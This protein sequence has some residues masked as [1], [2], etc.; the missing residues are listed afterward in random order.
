[1]GFVVDRFDS[2]SRSVY[3]KDDYTGHNSKILQVRDWSGY[4][5]DIQVIATDT[6]AVVT[7]KDG[8][9]RQFDLTQGNIGVEI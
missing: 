3:L 4:E 6:T 8:T 5:E 7:L 2:G 1:M 9:I